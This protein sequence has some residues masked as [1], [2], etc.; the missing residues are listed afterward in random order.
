MSEVAITWDSKA[1]RKLTP[2]RG[3]PNTSKSAKRVKRTG[4][5][6]FR[7]KYDHKSVANASDYTTKTWGDQ[8]HEVRTRGAALSGEDALDAQFEAMYVQV[9]YEYKDAFWRRLAKDLFAAH[10]ATFAVDVVAQM[11]PV[12]DMMYAKTA[13]DSYVPNWFIHEKIQLMLAPIRRQLALLGQ[14]EYDAVKEHA[15][16]IWEE[17]AD[18]LD[19]RLQLAYLFPDE[20]EWGE[21]VA[22]AWPARHTEGAEAIPGYQ[23]LS[24]LLYGTGAGKDA[25]VALNGKV[26]AAN[27]QNR[28]GYYGYGYGSQEKLWTS[29]FDLV[30]RHGEDAVDVLADLYARDWSSH[31]T[32]VAEAMAIIAH[33]RIAQAFADKLWQWS[34]GWRAT[35]KDF[36]IDMTY[37]HDHPEF[38]LDALRSARKAATK[39]QDRI[40]DLLADLTA[41]LEHASQEEEHAELYIARDDL[42]RGLSNPPWRDASIKRKKRKKYDPSA[43]A[44]L[45]TLPHEVDYALGEGGGAAY[46]TSA[47]QMRG[48]E[49]EDA[50]LEGILEEI[51]SSSWWYWSVS[52]ALQ[53]LSRARLLEFVKKV[54][55]RKLASMR[56][57]DF[58]HRIMGPLGQ[59]A[60]PALQ[61]YMRHTT[62]SERLLGL[63]RR[64]GTPELVRHVAYALGRVSLRAKGR[65]WVEAFPEAAAKGAI[66]G[67]L[68]ATDA[69]ER[70]GFIDAL[71]VA[72]AQDAELVQE[73]IDAYGEEV[74]DALP[75]L[76]VYLQCPT[77]MPKLPHF[78]TPEM[79]TPIRLKAD[80]SKLLPRE[81]YEDIG[82]MLKFSPP[83]SP[84]V[85]LVELG[86]VADETSLA[87]FAWDLFEAWVKADGPNK[88]S[89]VIQAV[90]MFGGGRMADRL[91]HYID[92]WY[93]SKV[94]KRAEKIMFALENDENP[95]VIETFWRLIQGGFNWALFRARDHIKR[96]TGIEGDIEAIADAKTPTFGMDAS[97][98]IDFVPG[99]D[100]EVWLDADLE[101][102]LRH[103]DKSAPE[104]DPTTRL[105]W[106]RLQAL[107]SRQNR[108]QAMRLER[109]M[110]TQRRW[111]FTD[112]HDTIYAHPL[113]G[114]I[115]QRIIWGTYDDTNTLVG[116]WRVDE[117]NEI[118]D[119]EDEPFAPGLGSRVGIVHPIEL[120]AEAIKAWTEVLSDYEIIQP[121]E[122]ITKPVTE[123]TGES[124][125]ALFAELDGKKTTLGALQQMC[126]VND[127]RDRSNR[128]RDNNVSELIRDLQDHKGVTQFAVSINFWPGFTSGRAEVQEMSAAVTL[129]HGGIAGR[130]KSV[131]WS[132][133]DPVE[134]AELHHE[135][136]VL[137]T[138]AVDDA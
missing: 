25:L 72:Y 135:L 110:K 120:D 63:M 1:K 36:V 33:P 94:N 65:R 89:W 56:P 16:G 119:V 128:K 85:G 28:S 132:S 58:E 74:A 67:L 60:L 68:K 86:E 9:H 80:P 98:K 42:P 18:E 100:L 138:Q 38:S 126:Y 29:T 44:G 21:A 15:R 118:I 40:D 78:W 73:V 22:D 133:V 54:D 13:K 30:D 97:R 41:Q 61:A 71:C 95:Y 45:K 125:L 46:D 113:L 64:V 102:H 47:A 90:A 130:K 35:S 77:R 123:A 91:P 34:T 82:L 84:Y 53:K 59:E 20:V 111:G 26:F 116:T 62:G 114:L 122:Q 8:A 99:S 83:G 137:M 17:R 51:E 88:E 107:C 27:T 75:D 11:R 23:N 55:E 43:F 136:S 12:R 31:P 14:D 37:L 108:F 7:A 4:P 24:A 2:W 131:D 112:W 52:Y 105:R 48:D 103:L 49:T 39:N 117:S 134:L 124:I 70:N 3:S 101:P 69:K 109:A 127:W 93:D 5:A 10:E 121:F 6:K 57:Y 76:D 96:I 32:P 129:S 115:A 19:L 50:V 104:L 106:E 87:D 81:I 66:P 92:R 79:W